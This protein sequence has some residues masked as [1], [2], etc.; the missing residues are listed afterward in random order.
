MKKIIDFLNEEITKLCKEI[1][2]LEKIELKRVLN[3]EEKRYKHELKG[4]LFQTLTIKDK[5]KESEIEEN[6]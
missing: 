3:E 5:A 6:D 4:A 1:D 2:Y